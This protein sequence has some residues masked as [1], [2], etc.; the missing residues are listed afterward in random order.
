M[1]EQ[2]AA[3]PTAVAAQPRRVPTQR[4]S[5]ERMERILTVA[6]DLIAAQG[7]DA[8]R[9]SEVAERASI[10]IGSLYQ[11]FP[12]KAAIMHTLAERFNA[13]GRRCVED[14]CAGVRSAAD[15]PVAFTQIVSGYYAMFL[16][17]PVM[18]DIWSGLQADRTL[19]A[20]SAAEGM[21]ITDLVLTA[22]VRAYPTADR[23]DL[24]ISAGLMMELTEA[25][26]RLAIGLPREV[27][28]AMVERFQAILIRELTSFGTAD[29]A[30]SRPP[31]A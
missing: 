23:D 31:S 3:A 18:R 11:Y 21:A 30:H 25:T 5:R 9:M 2:P 16:A 20:M 26:M 10:S 1:P 12:D 8:L 19:R 6:S 7:S 22:L 13:E 17:E 27:G 29:P 15:L 28:D 14:A 24:A 4:R